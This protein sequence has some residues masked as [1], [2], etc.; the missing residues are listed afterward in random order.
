MSVVCFFSSKFQWLHGAVLV[1]STISIL[2]W[3]HFESVVWLLLSK[4]DWNYYQKQIGQEVLIQ[5]Q[6]LTSNYGVLPYSDHFLKFFKSIDIR[7]EIFKS[8]D[9]HF[10]EQ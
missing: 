4:I 3:L 9:T 8:N 2:F 5:V 6:G 1:I 10:E 7:F